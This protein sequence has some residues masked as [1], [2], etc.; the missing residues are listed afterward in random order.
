MSP[1]EILP[2][3]DLQTLE[4]QLRNLSHSD[5]ALKII[6]DFANNLRKTRQ[7][8]KIFGEEGAL[9][10]PPIEYQEMLLRGVLKPDED[11]FLLLQ[12]DIVSTDSGYFLGERIS[13]S[14]FAIA[15]STCDLVS[16]RRQYAAL[17]RIHPIRATEE[18]AAQL[19]GELLKFKSTS[20]MY[21]PALPDDPDEVIANAILF[22]GIVQIRLDD[23]LLATRLAS[24]SMV[25]WRIFGSLLRSILVRA[26][27][28]EVE[29]R[30]S[31]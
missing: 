20:R 6:Q 14:K 11:P 26:G 5:E 24:L 8:Q 7:R 1:S 25:G 15:T 30:A 10:R 2:T 3:E 23:L 18:Y 31:L 27:V 9:V 17:L 16:G 12:G 13:G 4:T 22:D 29:M 21:L 28:S 19:L